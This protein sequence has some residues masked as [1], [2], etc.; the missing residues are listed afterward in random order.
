[1]FGAKAL[2]TKCN[3]ATRSRTK[4]RAAARRES[5][6]CLIATALL[7]CALGLVAAIGSLHTEV[8]LIHCC[9][10]KL[11]NLVWFASPK[12]FKI[13]GFGAAQ[14]G[15]NELKK[16]TTANLPPQQARVGACAAVRIHNDLIY[17]LV[18]IWWL[19]RVRTVSKG[20]RFDF[21]YI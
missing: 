11:R 6:S 1:M 14:G 18:P 10:I 4:D 17:L 3:E 21:M 9:E 2:L 5:C 19:C 15:G 8:G 12:K 16:R 20:S 13:T 7:R